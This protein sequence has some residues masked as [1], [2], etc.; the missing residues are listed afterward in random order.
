MSYDLT[1]KIFQ[2]ADAAREHLEALRWPDG[3]ICPH[4]GV[5]GSATKLVGKAH[6]PGVYQCND[7]REQFTVT[8]GTVFE[9]SKIPLNKWLLATHLMC[10][11]KKG[12]SAHQIGRMLGVTYKTAWFMCHR[13][14]EAMTEGSSGPLGG[15]NKVVEVDE[16]YVGGKAKNRAY[17]TPAAKKPVV[18]LV[19]R[20][21]SVKSFHVANVTG[22]NL[23]PLVMK[24]IDQE[25]HLMTDESPLYPK[26]GRKF[27]NHSTVN[28]SVKQYTKTGNFIHTNT[29]ENFFSIFKRGVIG[30]YH[31]LSEAHIGRY[32]AEFDFRYNNRKENDV[33]RTEKAL[34]A[35]AGKR[36]TYRRSIAAIAA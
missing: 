7:C 12:M 1:A 29:V 24:H 5:V 8:V 11:S 33:V 13:I 3:A 14:R 22:A 25:T 21:G 20:D 15:E 19:E 36:L 2:D 17:R 18:A 10:A 23:R 35:I 26:M 28:H 31:H 32:C 6:R 16:T 34:V 30:V 4:C 27:K 9:R